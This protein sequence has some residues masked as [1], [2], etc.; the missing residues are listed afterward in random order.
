MPGMIVIMAPAISRRR[1][2]SPHRFRVSG[3]VVQNSLCNS[4]T[5]IRVLVLHPVIPH[6]GNIKYDSALTWPQVDCP[7]LQ[8]AE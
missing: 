5:L 1:L 4:N 7:G 3:A 2:M 8:E 6:R